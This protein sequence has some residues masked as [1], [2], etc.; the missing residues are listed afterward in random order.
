MT[1]DHPFELPLQFDDRS[2]EALVSVWWTGNLLRKVGRR[3]FRSLDSSEAQF[4]VLFMLRK[5]PGPLTQND[6]SRRLLV[7]KANI[8]GLVDQLEKAG[9]VK[10]VRASND[11]RSY[12]VRITPRGSREVDR[13]SRAYDRTI[14]KI[15]AGLTRS[16]LTALIES[17]RKL[18]TAL[19]R[20][21]LAQ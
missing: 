15:A 11:R 21:G 13:L 16:D 10:R 19:A 4:N 5:L 6:L 8:T 14:E 17:T 9:L 3:L 7:D 20:S 12:H 18:R 1:T 2:H